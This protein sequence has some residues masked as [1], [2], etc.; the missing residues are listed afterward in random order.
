MSRWV[1]NGLDWSSK[2]TACVCMLALQYLLLKI[3]RLRKV[4]AVEVIPKASEVWIGVA[5]FWMGQLLL[6]VSAIAILKVVFNILFGPGFAADEKSSYASISRIPGFI[7]VLM[8]R[9]LV[10]WMLHHSLVTLLDIIIPFTRDRRRNPHRELTNVIS[11][12]SQLLTFIH[13]ITLGSPANIAPHIPLKIFIQDSNSRSTTQTVRLQR[14]QSDHPNEGQRTLAW[15]LV[16]DKDALD[17]M[18]ETLGPP[19]GFG[20]LGFSVGGYG[21]RFEAMGVGTS[22]VLDFEIAVTDRRPVVAVR[23]KTK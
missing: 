19:G 23:R 16:V 8:D 1:E 20:E 18:K 22:F 13:S 3:H 7:R 11:R 15:N 5:A 6:D 9:I 21:V 17:E 10:S 12:T 4:L 2:F 14:T